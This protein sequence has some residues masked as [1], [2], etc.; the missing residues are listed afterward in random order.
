MQTVKTQA[1]AQKRKGSAAVALTGLSSYQPPSEPTVLV[2]FGGAGDLA[3]RKLVPALFDLF[4]DGCLP[5]YFAIVIVDAV[6]I[7]EDELLER[8]R[9]GAKRFAQHQLRGKDWKEFGSH[10]SYF[11]ADFTNKQAFAQLADRLDRLERKWE[12]KALSIFYLATPPRFFGVIADMLGKAR[13]ARKRKQSRILVEKPIGHDLKSMLEINHTISSRFDEPQIFRID[14][15]LGKET[16]R[17]I[18]ALRFANVL[19]EPVWNRR[20]IDYVTITVAE[21]VGLE[22]RGGY[23]EGAG[24]LRDMVQNHLLQLLCL[25]AMEP[26]VSFDAD[27]LRNKKVDVLHAVRQIPSNSVWE[28]ATRGQY[29]AGTINGKQVPGYRQEPGV[30]PDSNTETFAAMKLFVDNWRW[31]DVP[32]YLRTGKRLAQQV[33]EIV[34]HFRQVPHQSFPPEA[35]GNW[36]PAA[37]VLCIQPQEGI[38]LRFQAK[39]P[40][41]QLILQPV[42]MHFNY[43]DAFREPLPDAYKT[44]LWDLMMGD[45]TIFMRADQVEAAWT[46]LTPVL[47][48]WQSLPADDFPNYA[49]GTMGPQ[50]AEVLL[51]RGGC[52]WPNPTSLPGSLAAEPVTDCRFEPAAGR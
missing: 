33:S 50:N 18:L 17:N 40:G 36:L 24:A 19:F 30:A 43:G 10:F 14:H 45:A 52:A 3:W 25:I 28:F 37:L 12:R 16:V 22:R 1:R 7:R 47:E 39:K 9:S 5:D 44:L 21:Q 13:L 15:Y 49:A 8:F 51:A 27:E 20:Y 11:R 35:A 46:I 32:F 26:P 31:Q 6:Q 34:I 23:Y 4:K 38:S 48:Y 29:G 42:S 41:A 2:I